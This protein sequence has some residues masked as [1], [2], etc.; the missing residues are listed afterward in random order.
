[1]G[2]NGPTAWAGFA[3]AETSCPVTR[4]GPWRGAGITS[5]IDEKLK[6]SAAVDKAASKVDELKGSLTDKVDDLKS[7]AATPKSE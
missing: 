3:P 5:K 1:M 4:A 7:K 6:L 2:R